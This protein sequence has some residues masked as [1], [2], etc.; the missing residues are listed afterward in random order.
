MLTEEGPP[1]RAENGI[2]ARPRPFADAQGDRAWGRMGPL[3]PLRGVLPYG[4]SAAP[5][6]FLSQYRRLAHPEPA[7]GPDSQ[8]DRGEGA[9]EANPPLTP[10]SASRRAQA[11]P[12]E[13][14]MA[15]SPAGPGGGDREGPWYCVAEVRVTRAGCWAGEPP[16]PTQER[17]SSFRRGQMRG[18]RLAA[19]EHP[20][21]W[22]SCSLG[23]WAPAPVLRQWDRSPGRSSEPLVGQVGSTCPCGGR[24][25]GQG[26]PAPPPPARGGT[27][28]LQTARFH[29]IGWPVG[30]GR[31]ER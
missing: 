28:A 10:G 2:P 30:P 8:P 23:R 27:R 18:G 26:F 9:C 3:T 4:P 19:A 22:V 7:E 20:A 11:R 14:A 17:A 13:R 29:P 1:P 5:V 24:A 21:R 31:T 15:P 12:P 6:P 16:V 25:V